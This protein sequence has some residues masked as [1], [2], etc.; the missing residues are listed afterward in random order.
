MA[1][2]DIDQWIGRAETLTD[3]AA[4]GPLER[5]A[6]LLD[7]EAAPWAAG[8]VPP[9]AY[10]LYFLP[11]ARQS[12]IDVD[13]HPKRGGDGLLPPIALPRRMWAG[14]RVSFAAPIP[15][16]AALT[17]TST[18]ASIQKKTGASGEMVF[19]TVKHEVAANGAPCVVEEQ[20]LVYRA[21]AP[22]AAAPAAPPKPPAPPAES[23]RSRTLIADPVQL[24]RFS[25]LTYNAHRIHYDREYATA[26]EGYPGLV[27]HGPYLATLL[28]DHFLRGQPGAAVKSFSF[29]AMRPAFDGSPLTLNHGR[30]ADGDLL[31]VS[32]AEGFTCMSAKVEA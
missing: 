1:E 31:W 8:Q 22:A 25:A 28:M 4:A 30:D 12:D 26:E 5:L 24:F 6:S 32:D 9:L 17:K 19:V 14:S 13:G 10:W 29:R 16:S 3:T 11:N 23:L 7:H 2:V 18:V 15:V 20:D 21:P 27:V